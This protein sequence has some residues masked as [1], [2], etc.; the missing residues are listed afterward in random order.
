MAEQILPL[1]TGDL[2]GTNGTNGT[3]GAETTTIAPGHRLV[4]APARATH[5]R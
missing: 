5:T 1:H 4:H 2:D 3:D